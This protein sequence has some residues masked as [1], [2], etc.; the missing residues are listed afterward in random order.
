M[1]RLILTFA[2]VF[3]A[4]AVEAI[5]ARRNAEAQLARGGVEPAGDVYRLMRF[6]YPVTF[7]AM[8]A[9]GTL[10]GAPP[11][12][13]VITGAAMFATAK[14]IK[15]WAIVALG[16]FWTFRVVVVPGAALVSRGPYRWLRH[17][18]Y[19]GV[20]GELA[21]V[22]LVTRA[23]WSGTASLV[24]FGMLIAKRIVVEERALAAARRTSPASKTGNGVGSG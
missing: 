16:P 15:W 6:A 12:A 14:A 9:E 22:A 24:I 10:R 18:N 17:P 19:V 2:V 7:L 1:A 5:R 23:V 11:L 3:A 8:L 20:I 4:M 21:G 13:A